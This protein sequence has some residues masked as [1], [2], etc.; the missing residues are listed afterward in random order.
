MQSRV[1]IALPLLF[2]PASGIMRAQSPS[3]EPLGAFDLN[4]EKR[5]GAG[6]AVA[7]FVVHDSHLCFS[8]SGLDGRIEF[9]TD[10]NGVV[11]SSGAVGGATEESQPLE[12]TFGIGSGKKGILRPEERWLFA[13]NEEEQNV[14]ILRASDHPVAATAAPDGKIYLLDR[15]GAVFRFD[16]DLNP[17]V[18]IDLALPREFHPRM[19][20]VSQGRIYL[21]DPSGKVLYHSLDAS[22]TTTV[23]SGPRLLTGEEPVQQAA[24]DAGYTGR[25]GIEL[26][27]TE[28]GRAR[29]VQVHGFL[30]NVAGVINAVEALRFRP[31][32]RDGKPAV[33]HMEVNLN[34]D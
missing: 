27:V 14:T 7:S 9:E 28:D 2:A 23:D 11:Q 12:Q 20:A 3:P 8:I 19:I 25:I 31:A 10:E 15:S 22:A 4:L 26:E 1:W 21:A 6:S 30:A 13:G 17:E 33:V 29:N 16:D 18:Q 5:A 34:V 24:R 32:I